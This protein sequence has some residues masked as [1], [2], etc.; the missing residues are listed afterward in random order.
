MIKGLYTSASGMLPRIK[1]Q[2]LTANNIANFSTPG[3]K[4]D[5][6][7]TR[8]LSRAE[9]QLALR[10]SD[11]EKPMVNEVYTDYTSGIFDK[12]GN[13]LD[14]A[15]DGDGF[16]TLE[17]ADGT[18]A[19]T[20]AGSFTVNKDGLLAFPG[21]PLL[22][23]EGGPIEVGN[24]KV[25]VAQ[26]GEVDVDGFVI[27]RI[28]PMTVADLDQVQKIGSSLFVVPEGVELIPVDKA[29]IRQGYLEASNVDIV[30]EMIDMIISFRNY[31]AN[32]RALQA[33]DQTLQHLFNRVG[34]NG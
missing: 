18:R 6:L 28:V 33:Q 12:T 19:L 10:R 22:I 23:G 16:F 24:G 1:K 3:Y 2:E 8:E 13:P 31:E 27:G 26:S 15:I 7:F 5:T 4:R 21:G 17:L 11:W 34:G 25:T 32:A 29:T 9:K 14:F 30:R 20:R